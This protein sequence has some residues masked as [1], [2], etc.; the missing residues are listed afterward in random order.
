MNAKFNLRE[1]K[2][3]KVID[4]DLFT[5]IDSAG[6]KKSAREMLFEH[7]HCH[8][9]V[10]TLSKYCKII[11]SADAFPKMQALGKT[12]LRAL[13]PEG[14]LGLLVSC[15]LSMC[16]WCVCLCVW[17]VRRPLSPSIG[18]GQACGETSS[19]AGAQGNTW[20]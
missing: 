10:A 9:D 1:L 14:L 19:Q 20:V 8:A 17:T 18:A 16:M 4:E 15:C 5:K 11:I 2:R 6:D 7:L 12:M 13:S 3:E